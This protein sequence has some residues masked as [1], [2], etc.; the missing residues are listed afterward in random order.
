VTRNKQPEIRDKNDLYRKA[1]KTALRILTGRDHSKYEL[2][3]K[4]KQRG[5]SGEV[6]GEVMSACKRFDYINDERT[7]QV[8]VRQ[9]NRKGY[10]IKRI[11]YELNKKGLKGKR[12]QG[13]LSENISAATEQECAQRVLQKHLK[14]FEREKD[15]LKKKSKIHRFLYSRGFSDEIIAELIRSFS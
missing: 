15:F 9:L 10:G 11:R 14:R 8:Y 1:L 4:L 12:I 13:I 7:A 5:F 2:E 6:I 3:Q